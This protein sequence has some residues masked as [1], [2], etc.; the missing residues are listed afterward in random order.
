MNFGA[1]RPVQLDGLREISNIGMGHAA[2]A[3]SQLIGSRI[4][5][6]VPR[7]TIAHLAEV[8]DLVGGSETLIAGVYMSVYG[9]AQ[10]SILLTFPRQSVTRLLGMLAPE[11]ETPKEGALTEFSASTL[12]EIGNILAGAYLNA[13]GGLLSLTLLPG[14]PSVAFDMAGAIVDYILIEIGAAGDLTLVIET[15][16]FGD[17]EVRGHFFMLPDPGSLEVLLAAGNMTS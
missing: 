12:R 9:D 3:L 8:P 5:L 15:E 2:T 10:G 4:D 17:P 11:G 16:F 6:H 13:L 1:L 14:V 7:V